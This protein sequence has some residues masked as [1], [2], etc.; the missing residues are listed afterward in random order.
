MDLIKICENC[1]SIADFD[2]Y[3]GAYICKCGWRDDSYDQDRV[4]KE[5]ILLNGKI[6]QM[7]LITD[8]D[9]LI[10]I[11]NFSDKNKL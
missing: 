2:S 8:D 5:E 4:K 6:E 10:K 11:R 7:E 9:L 3:F 1:G